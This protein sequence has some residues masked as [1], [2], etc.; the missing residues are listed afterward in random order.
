[1][2]DAVAWALLCTKM[3]PGIPDVDPKAHY[4]LLQASHRKTAKSGLDALCVLA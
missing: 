1:M 2:C 3:Q 4:V